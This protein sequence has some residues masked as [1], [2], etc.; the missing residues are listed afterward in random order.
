MASRTARIGGTTAA[1]TPLPLLGLS[2]Y[3]SS[4][5]SACA[6]V[7][8]CRAPLRPPLPLLPARPLFSLSTSLA[9]AAA[10]YGVD[11][12]ASLLS[13]SPSSP[14]RPS[15]PSPSPSSLP[16]F[17]A[18]ATSPSPLCSHCGVPSVVDRRCE[19]FDVDFL[20]AC[21]HCGEW[22]H[23]YHT[24]QPYHTYDTHPSHHSSAPTLLAP[25]SSSLSFSS[26]SLS[27]SSSLLFGLR[28][29]SPALDGARDGG[30]EG[31]LRLSSVQQP[32]I[33]SLPPLDSGE[34]GLGR[35]GS[36]ELSGLG[37][38]GE[39]GGSSLS[40][41]FAVSPSL[42]LS[43]VDG[44]GCLSIRRTLSSSERLAQPHFAW[45]A[46][47]QLSHPSV[48]STRSSHPQHPQQQT[49]P[50]ALAAA[51]DGQL[52]RAAAR[53]DSGLPSSF[54]SSSS[55]VSS[56]AFVLFEERLHAT[57][58][59]TALPVAR[60]LPALPLATAFHL[61]PSPAHPSGGGADIGWPHFRAGVLPSLP[62]SMPAPAA[63]LPLQP[64]T[65]PSPAHPSPS[66]SPSSSAPLA[67]PLSAFSVPLSADECLSLACVCV[68]DLCNR[69]ALSAGRFRQRSYS[70][71]AHLFTQCTA[72]IAF[73]AHKHLW[74]NPANGTSTICLLPFSAQAA[75][76]HAIATA[77]LH[78][79]HRMSAKESR[80][81]DDSTSTTAA[82][83]L[84]LSHVPF[85]SSSPLS[86]ISGFVSSSNRTPRMPLPPLSLERLRSL[87]LGGDGS[88]PSAASAVLPSSL[89]S[90]YVE[91]VASLMSGVDVDS[92]TGC[93][94][95]GSVLASHP[96]LVDACRPSF[97]A[98]ANHFPLLDSATIVLAVD[99]LN[100]AVRLN[101]SHRRN[102][103]S[104]SAATLFLACALQGVRLTQHEF[105]T[106][107][108]LTEVTLR[109]VNKEL[110]AH[111]R[112]LVPEGYT[113][114]A[115]PPFL[116]KHS[117]SQRAA[118]HHSAQA[119]H[120]DQVSH[121]LPKAEGSGARVQRAIEEETTGPLVT[122]S[123][124][125][126][127][128]PAV[129]NSSEE[130]KRVAAEGLPPSSSNRS[131]PALPLTPLTVPLQAATSPGPSSSRLPSSSSPSASLP[132][133]Y[134]PPSPPTPRVK[135]ETL[136][137]DG[138]DGAAV[139]AH[140]PQ[141]LAT[142]TSSSSS[143]ASL[144]RAPSTASSSIW[145]S[146]SAMSSS[147]LPPHVLTST[148]RFSSS[149]LLH[150]SAES[151]DRR[152][153]TGQTQKRRQRGDTVDG[154]NRLSVSSSPSRSSSSGRR[155]PSS[156]SDTEEE[157]E[158][159]EGVRVAES[160]AELAG[161]DGGGWRL[162]SSSVEGKA[163]NGGGDA[164]SGVA[165]ALARMPL[166][167]LPPFVPTFYTITSS[168]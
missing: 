166:H 144:K 30:Q 150:R 28:A 104:L 89:L 134:A 108:G 158:E 32:H 105:C 43:M 92:L 4:S 39:Y 137:E 70:T 118:A 125:L 73:E 58:A 56:S 90:V 114:K 86:S 159:D 42:S 72:R 133:A 24:Y 2:P 87:A 75:H 151:G 23:T 44:S 14:L 21:E 40:S 12:S 111:W 74:D 132:S 112:S 165:A 130:R 5:P 83:A 80:E 45:E 6:C 106:K 36:S 20:S 37:G 88:S 57:P 117:H 19:G 152:K 128:P 78:F 10:G 107:I 13:A 81:V 163:A 113:E 1:V 148:F 155:R 149:P 145:L 140:Q 102:H 51:D 156:E 167:R 127:L 76:V 54:P 85:P 71:L 34:T 63:V 141:S 126:P 154:A 53:V 120:R 61:R 65:R 95:A 48:L 69:L 138:E 29:A 38:E 100:A 47:P 162:P 143:S 82:P 64:P 98:Y 109:K 153:E 96:L 41:L 131:Q 101:L 26:S 77:V 79:V 121:S 135:L 25:P 22:L 97:L 147:L 136:D 49:R 11:G 16:S 50:I 84:S 116:A 67:S 124:P 33:D 17:S 9:A 160:G 59:L 27:R 122:H 123:R 7:G 157:A 161:V 8:R 99:M 139:N 91:L 66:A 142:T 129:L 3:P 62:Q 168:H 119:L 46:Q 55:A 68:D 115:L 94:S 164:G 103:S 31:E 60:T 35:S 15:S 18:A 52:E 110:G 93:A 146:L